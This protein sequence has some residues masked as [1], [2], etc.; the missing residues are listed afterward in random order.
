V[1]FGAYQGSG[2]LE[3]TFTQDWQLQ[4]VLGHREPGFQAR[5][6]A[7]IRAGCDVIA[8]ELRPDRAEFA[9]EAAAKDHP[10]G[11]GRLALALQTLLA[12]ERAADDPVIAAGF[13]ELAR[14]EI[15]ETYSLATAILAVEAKYVSPRER[16]DLL[17]GV[18]KAPAARRVS[19][20]DGKLLAAWTARLLD[21]R[22]GSVDGAYRSRWW[23]LGGK[24][25]D[26]SNSQY[27]LLALWS[28]RLCQ[29]PIDTSTWIAAATHWLDVQHGKGEAARP[30][31]LLDMKQLRE[32]G[33]AALAAAGSAR[34]IAPRGFCYTLPATEPAY[35]SMTCAGLAGLALCAAALDDGSGKKNAI[36]GRIDD[37]LRAGFAWLAAHRTVRWNAGPPPHRNEFWFYWLYSLE[38]ACELSRVGLI[39]TWDWY[40][41][42]AQVLLALQDAD[43]KFSGSLEDQCLAVLFLKKAQQPVLT[44]PR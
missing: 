6:D 14:R 34:T 4:A 21:N 9:T 32:Q 20:D 40:H 29:Q 27:A 25:F 10:C 13:A 33:S 38:R 22:D 8:H 35:G 37:G 7:A 42:G 36:D 5:V 41:D 19:A 11:E 24:G 18:L 28:A 3:G 1:V 31:R 17:A 39:D 16:D 12:A 43:G 2:R 15:V 26:N 23:Y 30:L 44:G